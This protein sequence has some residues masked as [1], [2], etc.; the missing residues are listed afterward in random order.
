M[1][2]AKVDEDH[3][4]FANDGVIGEVVDFPAA[5][6]GG[7]DGVEGV[8]VDGFVAGHFGEDETLD[9]ALGHVRSDLREDGGEDGFVEA[10]GS[11][12]EGDLSGGFDPAN[13][14]GDGKRGDLVWLE[15]FLPMRE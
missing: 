6:A 15:G 5:G 9:P 3:L 8:T 1:D 10:L 4:V 7:D 13:V 12:H 2:D 14:L 11:L